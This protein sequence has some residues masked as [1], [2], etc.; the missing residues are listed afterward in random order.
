MA[1]SRRFLSSDDETREFVKVLDSID[2]AK[3]TWELFDDFTTVMACTISNSADITN[4]DQREAEYMRIV[5]KYKPDDFSKFAQLGA[6]LTMAIIDDSDR[7]FLGDMY[8]GLDLLDTKHQQFFTPYPVS[9]F[10][11]YSQ[12]LADSP[13]IEQNGYISICDPSCGSGTMLI[14]APNVLQA[15]GKDPGS[16]AL[17]VGKDID[18]CVAKMC[19]ITLSLMGCAAIVKVCNALSFEPVPRSHTWV[20]PAFLR[21]DV[22]VE[23]GYSARPDQMPAAA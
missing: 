18:R 13:T 21:D 19:Y 2:R 6:L 8:G 14:A 11:A 3:S 7:D 22:W 10:M 23:R 12:S 16:Q 15:A 20:S 4:Y 1:R 9:K 5:K 17:F